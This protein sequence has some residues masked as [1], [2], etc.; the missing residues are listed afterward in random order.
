MLTAE[1]PA[2]D[3]RGGFAREL[4]D[5]QRAS[6]HQHGDNWLGLTT[7]RAPCRAN[8]RAGQLELRAWQCD[9]SATRCLRRHVFPLAEY[10][11]DCIGL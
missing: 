10:E 1:E 3:H 8:H 9:R 11:D 4:G 2:L 6:I 5:R 7:A